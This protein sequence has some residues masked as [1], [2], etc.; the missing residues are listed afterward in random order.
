MVKVYNTRS[1]RDM[2]QSDIDDI[3]NT[4][5]PL[6]FYQTGILHYGPN[7][8]KG[9]ERVANIGTA[10]SANKLPLPPSRLTEFFVERTTGKSNLDYR[11]II[12]GEPGSGKSTT[13]FYLGGRYGVECA[14]FAKWCYEHEDDKGVDT[15]WILGTEPKDYFK[16]EN[17]CLLQDTE[18]LT[19]ILDSCEDRQAI[20]VDD[21]GVTVGNKDSQSQKN[22]NIG[23]IMQVVRT[24]RLLLLWNAPLRKHIE[25]QVRELVYAKG[26]IFKSCHAAG[27]N[28]M[29][30][31]ITKQNN[32]NPNA[33]EWKNRF[34]F[35]GHKISYYLAYSPDYIDGYEGINQKYEIGR[36]NA[37]N[38]LVS[39]RAKQEHT[40]NNPIDKAMESWKK[41][42]EKYFPW[43][44]EQLVNAKLTGKK[45]KRSEI[46]SHCNSGEYL[47]MEIK[48]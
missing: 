9:V 17:C 7:N 29:R 10:I 11:I 19:S 31:N 46:M 28:I 25:L 22:K 40:R 26:Y 15:D 1:A 21:A 13:F 39:T 12:D 32:E 14:D 20:I 38:D 8:R 3:N 2:P 30:I 47:T 45:F 42:L 36:K 24:K 43:V 18:K 6:A 4:G 41:K 37:A 44:L 48:K 16:L 5:V 23:A 33:P 27:F 35:D 34:A